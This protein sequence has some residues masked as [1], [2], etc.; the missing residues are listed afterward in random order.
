MSAAGTVSVQNP[1]PC[2]GEQLRDFHPSHLPLQPHHL[3]QAAPPCHHRVSPKQTAMLAQP[4]TGVWAQ[5]GP[6]LTQ[7]S[8]VTRAASCASRQCLQ[9]LLLTQHTLFSINS[10]ESCCSSINWPY[11][12]SQRGVGSCQLHPAPNLFHTARL[13]LYTPH[14]WMSL[15]RGYSTRAS[16]SRVAFSP[17]AENKGH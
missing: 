17:K 16:W 14:H 3:C 11:A 1:W 8:A 5:A 9:R 2:H 4:A 7:L 15:R 6:A 13:F 10:R 12:G